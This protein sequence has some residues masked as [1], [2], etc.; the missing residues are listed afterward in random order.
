MKFLG[1]EVR[2][3]YLSFEDGLSVFT[4]FSEK[5]EAA[6]EEEIFGSETIHVIEAD[7]VVDRLQRLE[8]ALALCLNQRDHILKK[9]LDP[10]VARHTI[11]ARN[12]EISN[13][14]GDIKD[15]QH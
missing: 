9:Y 15:G 2:E 10:E 5:E 7:P 8:N 4:A 1:I 3:F 11:E 14:L 6:A 12:R 13:M